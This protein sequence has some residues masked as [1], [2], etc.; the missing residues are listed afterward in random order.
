MQSITG[1]FELITSAYYFNKTVQGQCHTVRFL[2]VMC[3][4][5]SVQGTFFNFLRNYAYKATTE[6]IVR[7]KGYYNINKHCHLKFLFHQPVQIYSEQLFPIRVSS[8][9]GK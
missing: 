5:Y 2:T 7:V 1:S 4:K 9:C 6:Y 3:V 8:I